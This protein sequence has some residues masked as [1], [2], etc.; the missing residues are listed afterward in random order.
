MRTPSMDARSLFNS[1]VLDR[2]AV[3]IQGSQDFTKK[4][5]LARFDL[6]HRQRT[7]APGDPEREGG[8]ATAGS[9]IEPP[10]GRAGHI[11]N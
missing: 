9:Q 7:L 3:Q 1:S 2:G 10:D 4:R 8:R 5:R 11:W 6:D